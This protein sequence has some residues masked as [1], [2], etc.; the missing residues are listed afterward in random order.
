MLKKLLYR[1]FPPMILEVSTE[2]PAQMT[3]H[4]LADLKQLPH[5]DGFKYILQCLRFEKAVK[6]QMLAKEDNPDLRAEVKAFNW[7]ESQL[8][9]Y[10]RM[11]LSKPRPAEEEEIKLFKKVS[12]SIS[13][14]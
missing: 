6:L 8:T 10:A 7:L 13:T 3:E 1:L 12:A 11:N 14:I 2:K 9:S 4:V 5:R